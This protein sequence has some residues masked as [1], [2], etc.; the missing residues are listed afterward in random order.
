[1]RNILEYGISFLMILN[2]S[3]CYAAEKLE[4]LPELPSHSSISDVVADTSSLMSETSL[5]DFLTQNLTRELLIAT[6][7]L[8]F[9]GIVAL[10]AGILHLKNTSNKKQDNILNSSKI[11]LLSTAN[12]GG[13][14]SLHVIELDGKKM[15]IG[16]SSN[17]I[18]LLKDLDTNSE[19][20][21]F[22][23]DFSDV[24]SSE[25]ENTESSHTVNP[26]DYD[27]YKKYLV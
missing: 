11:S 22:E 23:T 21:D 6:C 2:S 17:V 1:M 4:V 26:D 10:T 9:I 19:E 16:A 15:L 12:L 27:L 25:K 20:D 8:F 18:Q 7:I 14:K 24:I 5:F 3:V 13:N